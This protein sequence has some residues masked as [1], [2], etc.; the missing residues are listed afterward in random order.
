MKYEFK[1]TAGLEGVVLLIC[2]ANHDV[3]ARCAVLSLSKCERGRQ[4][5]AALILTYYLFHNV[6]IDHVHSHCRS[7]CGDSG[8]LGMNTRTK[9]GD[10]GVCER[11][12]KRKRERK[13]VKG[14]RS[15][16]KQY[17]V[18]LFLVSVDSVRSLVV[19]LTRLS[20]PSMS[21]L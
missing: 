19:P 20:S 18:L 11:E 13:G 10:E 16:N 9:F 6:H 12:K 14:D 2:G 17:V 21:L 15:K 8:T 7:D 1:L 5:L 4:A 3:N